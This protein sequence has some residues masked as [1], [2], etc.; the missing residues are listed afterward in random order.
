MHLIFWLNAYLIIQQFSILFLWRVFLSWQRILFS[1][2]FPAKEKILYKVILLLKIDKLTEGQGHY[3]V[4]YS[5]R[6]L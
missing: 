3:I 2:I 5:G 4:M 1:I 6:R